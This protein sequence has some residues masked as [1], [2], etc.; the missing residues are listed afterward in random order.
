MYLS[1]FCNIFFV[2]N[3]KL[4]IMRL[5]YYDNVKINELHFKIV[6]IQLFW[7]IFL[8][9]FTE[10]RSIISAYCIRNYCNDNTWFF[11]WSAPLLKIVYSCICICIKL[12]YSERHIFLLLYPKYDFYKT[13]ISISEVAQQCLLFNILTYEGLKE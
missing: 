3:F 7:F 1:N 10:I 11:K 6:L 4:R 2:S 9:G 12:T 13:C 8:T 5:T